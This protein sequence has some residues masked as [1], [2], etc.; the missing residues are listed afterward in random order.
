MFSFEQASVESR[1]SNVLLWLTNKT[2]CCWF[3]HLVCLCVLHFRCSLTLLVP[4]M[5]W[6]WSAV[7]IVFQGF[8][9]DA[10][11]FRLHHD[12]LST[13]RHLFYPLLEK[14]IQ[15]MLLVPYKIRT[16]INRFGQ[17]CL[18][19][20]N[21]NVII[22]AETAFVNMNLQLVKSEHPKRPLPIL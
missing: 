22:R 8:E 20:D 17:K 15:Q 18:L 4:S 21:W 5:T 9:P 10:H 16:I 13:L 6:P 12:T 2:K 3:L 14:E 11:L 7:L 1:R 19:S